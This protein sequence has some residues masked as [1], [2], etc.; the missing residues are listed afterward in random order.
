LSFGTGAAAART[1]EESLLRLRTEELLLRLR[2]RLPASPSRTSRRSFQP[3]HG[4]SAT[5]R[6]SRSAL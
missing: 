4:S 3:V 2:R 6:W 1:A 5:P